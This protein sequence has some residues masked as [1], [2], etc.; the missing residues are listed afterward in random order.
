MDT[1]MI[2]SFSFYDEEE[3]AGPTLMEP[4][5]EDFETW[6]EALFELLPRFALNAETG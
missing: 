6:D 4:F 2:V 3:F 1:Y 5:Q